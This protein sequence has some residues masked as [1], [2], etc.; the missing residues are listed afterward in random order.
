M[1]NLWNGAQLIEQVLL[2]TLRRPHKTL[3]QRLRQIRSE[4]R[5]DNAGNAALNHEQGNST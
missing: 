4:Q 3:G 5:L 2:C 1:T